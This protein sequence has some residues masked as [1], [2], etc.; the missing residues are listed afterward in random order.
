MLVD[1][2][3]KPGLLKQFIADLHSGKLHREFHHGPD[4]EAPQLEQ[5]REILGH[6]SYHLAPDVLLAALSCCLITSLHYFI[7][8]QVVAFVCVS[9]SLFVLAPAFT[10]PRLLCVY[11]LGYECLHAC[12]LS[13]QQTPFIIL[14][15]VTVQI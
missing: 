8:G 5:V 4:P 11:I 10:V 15:A 7:L 3:R 1:I 14:F 6:S 2:C 9:L 13:V 12:L